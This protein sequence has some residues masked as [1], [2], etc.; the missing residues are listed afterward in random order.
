MIVLNTAFYSI[1]KIIQL[2]CPFSS[3]N[4]SLSITYTSIERLNSEHI[5]ISIKIGLS[6]GSKHGQDTGKIWA[7]HGQYIRK[8]HKII[9]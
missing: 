8:K 1:L 9:F 7:K 3:D 6:M 2:F 5:I 4:K